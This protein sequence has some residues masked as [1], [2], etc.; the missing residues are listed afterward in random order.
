VPDRVI[1]KVHCARPSCPSRSSFK[2]PGERSDLTDP[3]FWSEENS[4]LYFVLPSIHVT[5]DRTPRLCRSTP[6]FQH[7]R[8]VKRPFCGIYCWRAF[9]VRTSSRLNRSSRHAVKSSRSGTV[10]TNQQGLSADTNN[11]FGFTFE[12]YYTH[13]VVSHFE[14]ADDTHMLYIERRVAV[15]FVSSAP[16][17]RSKCSTLQPPRQK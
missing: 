9:D 15:P 6:L 8:R 4:G 16:K 2:T 11:R 14:S 7:G 1:R 3:D 13:V 10:D 12:A 17:S 5:V